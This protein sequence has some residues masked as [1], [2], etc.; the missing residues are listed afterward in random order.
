MTDE[1]VHVR[2]VEW[3]V[4]RT[5]GDASGYARTNC[6]HESWAPGR[7]QLSMAVQRVN[8][9]AREREIDAHVRRLSAR[10]Q[11]TLAVYYCKRLPQ[12]EQARLLGCQ[13]STVR[14]R[15]GEAR[16]Q[17]AVFYELSQSL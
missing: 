14:A 10:L 2:L 13:P 3:A 7:G 8:T 12:S 16:R 6:L 17:I 5:V 4:W 15:V 11:D 1:Q 9:H